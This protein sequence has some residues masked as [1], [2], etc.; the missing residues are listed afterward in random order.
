MPK[1]TDRPVLWPIILAGLIVFLMW[2]LTSLFRDNPHERME[3]EFD[4]ES[5]TV[6][7]WG[8]IGVVLKSKDDGKVDA[9]RFDAED[10]SFVASERKAGTAAI[11]CIVSA[12]TGEILM[13]G[14]K[15]TLYVSPD[16]P[17][18]QVGP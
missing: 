6:M 14:D 18:A 4:R 15:I 11:D 12:D 2:N 7:R 1:M 9:Q 5:L 10:V 8:R 16:D 17:M 3:F 13:Y